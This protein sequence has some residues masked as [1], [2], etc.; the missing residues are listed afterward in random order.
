MAAEVP[1]VT[2]QTNADNE[3]ELNAE[4]IIND[5]EVEAADMSELLHMNEGFTVDNDMHDLAHNV[6][7]SKNH[8]YVH[9]YDNEFHH[10]SKHDHHNSEGTH[11]ERFDLIN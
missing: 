8:D 5:L 1:R 2:L 3:M 4:K 11:N 6:P 9:I 7:T 10:D